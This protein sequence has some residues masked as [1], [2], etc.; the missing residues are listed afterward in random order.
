MLTAH[1]ALALALALAV[2]APVA[3]IAA[4]RVKPIAAVGVYHPATTPSGPG[5]QVSLGLRILDP[6]PAWVSGRFDLLG[7]GLAASRFSSPTEEIDVYDGELLAFYPAWTGAP[8]GT[9]LFYAAGAGLSTVTRDGARITRN[10]VYSASGGLTG[11]LGDWSV[12]G[13]VKLLLAPHDEVFDVSGTILQVTLG[14]G[15]DVD[16]VPEAP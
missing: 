11:R 2:L 12:E 15:V 10:P 9:R 5:A 7:Y 3:A 8:R 14:R 4:S 6:G 1:R 13:R 16:L